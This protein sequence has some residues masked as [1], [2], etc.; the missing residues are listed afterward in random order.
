MGDIKFRTQLDPPL[1]VK[2]IHFPMSEVQPGMS[3]SISQMV[4]T[5]RV[6][7]NIDEYEMD[8]IA[9]NA[10]FESEYM[11]FFDMADEAERLEA[12]RQASKQAPQDG[13]KP[14][15]NVTV[16]QPPAESQEAENE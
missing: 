4:K 9:E 12:E 11:D 5:R 15:K 1:K 14:P 2:E 13:G 10:P 7:G 8:G 3:P 6:G 16:N